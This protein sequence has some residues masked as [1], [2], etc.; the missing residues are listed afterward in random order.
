VLVSFS[1]HKRLKRSQR[2]CRRN[3]NQKKQRY[4]HSPIALEDK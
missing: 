1:V 2:K 3:N 4:Q